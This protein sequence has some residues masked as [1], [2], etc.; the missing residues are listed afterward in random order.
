MSPELITQREGLDKFFKQGVVFMDQGKYQEA[1]VKFKKSLKKNPKYLPTYNN[2]FILCLQTGQKADI[3]I[4][5]MD[6]ALLYHDNVPWVWYYK[7]YLLK[8]SK[9]F[10]EAIK[11]LDKSLRYDPKNCD[12]L[13]LKGNS[14]RAINE[15]DEAI[16]CFDK[17]IEIEPFYELAR[18]NKLSLLKH[19]N[20][21][22]ELKKASEEAA[23]FYY[24]KGIEYQQKEKYIPAI[25]HYRKSQNYDKE[26][27]PVNNSMEKALEEIKKIQN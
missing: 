27:L 19:L 13:V 25:I 21:I 23:E 1:I 5:L 8:T 2:L 20:K 11:A 15:N 18:T 24:K 17:A 14:H 9:K 6:Q 16:K 4:Q 7:G 3:T 12:T 26:Y 22:Y 10:K